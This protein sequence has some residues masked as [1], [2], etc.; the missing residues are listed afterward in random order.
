MND[1]LE[2]LLVALIGVCLLGYSGVLIFAVLK[3]ICA[4]QKKY[5]P[6]DGDSRRFQP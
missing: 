4:V 2:Y 6:F 3:N 5:L 1:T